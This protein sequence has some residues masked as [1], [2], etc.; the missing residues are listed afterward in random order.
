MKIGIIGGGITG[1]VAAY[2]LSQ[3]GQKVSIFEKNPVL[4]GMA[5]SFEVTPG[6]FLEIFYHHLFAG[7]TEAISLINE[8]NVGPKL[9]WL[10]SRMGVF[11][12]NTIFPFGTPFD[13]LKFTPLSLLNRL[14]LGL[15]TWYLTQTNNW[16]ALENTTA[17]SW[18]ARRIGT[19][20][21]RVFWKPL[22]QSK[23]G[24]AWDQVSMAWFWGKIHLR[25]KN[26][27]S[28]LQ[29]EKLGYLDG[30]LKLLIDALEKSIRE[31]GGSFLLA[32][33][34]VK[35][36]KDIHSGKFKIFVEEGNEYEFDQVIATIPSPLFNEITPSLDADYSNLLQKTRYSAVVCL[37][38]VLKKNLT[39]TYWLNIPQAEFPFV[40]LIEHTNFISHQNYGGYHILYITR[41][42]EPQHEMY[43]LP[44][45]L[46]LKRYIPYLQKINPH[47]QEEW[48]QQY[49]VFKN[50]H[51]QPIIGI[52]YSQQIPPM[53][54]P[55]QGLYLANTSQIYPEDRGINYSIR[56]GNTVS[57][58]LK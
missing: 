20:T 46:L 11:L 52:Q 19:T 38:V 53:Q 6:S 58:L 32:T 37:I 44:P 35:I 12:N 39:T 18:L 31:K 30:S 8:L 1:L 42:L 49:F 51:A 13:L 50:L 27:P 5:Q 55:I 23:F 9:Q 26:R 29:R 24:D 21:F 7:D 40:G 4:G 45:G 14:R 34:V 48:I 16:Q 36:S 22:L 56:L 15:V 10:E 25:G 17:A 3:Q 2:R 28:V 33:Q 47:F 41:Y 43:E 54:T 57:E